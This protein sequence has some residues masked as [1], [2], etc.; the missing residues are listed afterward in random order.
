MQSEMDVAGGQP[1]NNVPFSS[2]LRVIRAGN[3]RAAALKI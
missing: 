3:N 1:I 2:Q